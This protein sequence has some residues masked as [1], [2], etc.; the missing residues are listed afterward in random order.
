MKPEQMQFQGSQV[1]RVP[2]IPGI[3][4]WYYKPLVIN[5]E[6]IGNVLS[7]FFKE[8]GEISSEIKMRYGLR[9]VSNS[10]VET[11]YGSRHESIEDILSDSILSADQFLVDL[12]KSNALFFFTRPI[13]IGIAKNLYERIYSQH[14]L[15]ISELWDDDSSVSRHL[16]YFP[17]ATTQEVIKKLGIN[18]SFALE[19]RVRRIPLRDLM[20]HIFPTESIPADALED[21]SEES[22]P[23]RRA[24]EKLLQLIS[25]PICGRQ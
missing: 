6:N 25:D 22:N 3:Y 24:L 7:S 11:V 20:V 1:A 23:S 10:F 19:A 14:Y 2:N 9:F 13:Y 16:K 5:A 21:D 18:H 17:E 12:F 15:S 4:A 8:S